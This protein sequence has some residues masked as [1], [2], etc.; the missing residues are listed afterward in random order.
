[1]RRITAISRRRKRRIT[2]SGWRQEPNECADLE[3]VVEREPEGEQ[4]VS[5]GL[6]GDE[7]G[8]HDPVHHPPHVPKQ[9][10]SILYIQGLV[11]THQ[12][13]IKTI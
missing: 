3:L 8:E 7:Q 5:E 11:L 4:D 13:R 10:T 9:G 6:D 12:G 2:V 1:M